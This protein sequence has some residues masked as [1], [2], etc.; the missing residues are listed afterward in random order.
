MAEVRGRVREL[1]PL[2][3]LKKIKELL[4]HEGYLT[5]EERG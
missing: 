1:K 3:D 5:T 2:T 4:K